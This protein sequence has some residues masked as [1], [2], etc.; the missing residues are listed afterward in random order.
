M[1]LEPHP[2]SGEVEIEEVEKIQYRRLD[3]ETLHVRLDVEEFGLLPIY[4]W[5]ASD[6]QGGGPGWR[7]H[8]LRVLEDQDDGT[9]WFETESQA[10]EA[11]QSDLDRKQMHTLNVP[12]QPPQKAEDDDDDDDYWNSYDQTPGRTP[13]QHSPAPRQQTFQS[14]SYAP[15]TTEQD[16]YARYASEVQ[17]ALD[18]HDPDEE[19]PD[20]GQS[21]LNGNALTSQAQPNLL[22]PATLQTDKIDSAIA[23]TAA[24]A[25]PIPSDFLAPR[26]TSPSSSASERSVERL[27]EKAADMTRAEI[28]VKQHISSEVKNLLRL[29]RSVGLDRGEFERIVRT[30]LDVLGMFDEEEEA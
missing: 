10:A 12:S 9:E 30:Q 27:E 26:P 8:E 3:V 14:N 25:P 19:H 5:C 4:V 7:L 22:R 6:E 13:A 15:S 17:P 28:G 24:L 21:T 16:Y 23:S 29:A 18:S 2:V 11:C 20:A 1:N